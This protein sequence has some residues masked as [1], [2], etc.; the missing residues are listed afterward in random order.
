MSGISATAET[1]VVSFIGFHPIQTHVEGIGPI[2][3]I[4][5]FSNSLCIAI[6]LIMN[7][8]MENAMANSWSHALLLKMMQ[9][10]KSLVCPIDNKGILKSVR[11]SQHLLTYVYYFGYA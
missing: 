5:F 10:R 2:M 1:S 9:K 7:M 8:L 6:I 3:Q 4:H 11:G